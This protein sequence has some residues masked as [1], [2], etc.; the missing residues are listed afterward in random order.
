M[1]RNGSHSVSFSDLFWRS[2]SFSSFWARRATPLLS[3]LSLRRF[4]HSS[5]HAGLFLAAFAT[6][7]LT[8]AVRIAPLIADPGSTACRFTSFQISG[9]TSPRRVSSFSRAS[10]SA[11]REAGPT[12]IE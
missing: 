4:S 5:F 9:W 12:S 6:L 11:C 1:K 3:L 8:S 2:S 7:A 10:L